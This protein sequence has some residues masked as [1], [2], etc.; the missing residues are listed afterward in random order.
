M[1]DEEYN[2][3]I[4]SFAHAEEEEEGFEDELHEDED[5][6]VDASVASKRTRGKE[7]VK[8]K[9]AKKKSA[10]SGA[11]HASSALAPAAVV[12]ARLPRTA[13]EEMFVEYVTVGGNEVLER[14]RGRL[15]LQQQTLEV[16]DLV[17]DAAEKPVFTAVEGSTLGVISG[18]PTDLLARLF[19][20]HSSTDGLRFAET[21]RFLTS[22]CK[23]LRSFLSDPR[24][25]QSVIA[26][27]GN[28]DHIVRY[29]P[30]AASCRR[31]T[32]WTGDAAPRFIVNDLLSVNLCNLK[33]ITLSGGRLLKDFWSK[34]VSL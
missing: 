33:E 9:R 2:D 26:Q 23:S 14:A 5:E 4:S 34:K 1:S 19:G 22:T 27:S 3:E 16:R 12:A 25:F 30:G 28:L 8:T 29:A 24:F 6:F 13:L 21:Y 32:I 20:S 11:A 18:F 17:I 31:L 10:K 7:N 15:H